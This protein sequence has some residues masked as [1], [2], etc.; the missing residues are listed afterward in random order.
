MSEQFLID[1]FNDSQ[2][3]HATGDLF[4][5]WLVPDDAPVVEHYQG[6][7]R[8]FSDWLKLTHTVL[9]DDVRQPH[10]HRVIPQHFGPTVLVRVPPQKLVHPRLPTDRQAHP[11]SIKTAV[12][13]RAELEVIKI[14]YN[15]SAS[16]L[17]VS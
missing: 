5:K 11:P 6:Q 8:H 16:I 14:D 3:V 1:T 15:P 2:D 7:H 4:D 13:T 10:V 17:S 12:C 9:H